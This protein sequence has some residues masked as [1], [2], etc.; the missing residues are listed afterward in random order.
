MTTPTS[1]LGMSNIQTEF[2]GSNPIALSEYYGVNANVAVSG[3]ITMASFLGI[4]SFPADPTQPSV[5]VSF[6]HGTLS[7]AAGNYYTPFIRR[8]GDLSGRNSAGATFMSLDAS[9]TKVWANT[10]TTVV[11]GFAPFVYTSFLNPN[12]QYYSQ[13][14]STDRAIIV[15]QSNTGV[16]LLASNLNWGTGNT[17]AYVYTMAPTSGTQNSN[18]SI[19]LTAVSNTAGSNTVYSTLKLNATDM[20]T[21]E[22][23]KSVAVG[24]D[25]ADSTSNIKPLYIWTNHNESSVIIAGTV[26]S[27]N[28]GV[29]VLRAS[30]GTTEQS[31]KVI[32]THSPIN[33]TLSANNIAFTN[34]VCCWIKSNTGSNVSSIGVSNTS[35]RRAM[36][37]TP[38]YDGDTYLWA[39]AQQGNTATVHTM[40]AKYNSAGTRQ[41]QIRIESLTSSNAAQVLHMDAS[42]TGVV[43][44]VYEYTMA[45][46]GKKWAITS[47]G[48]IRYLHIS[49]ASGNTGTMGRFSLTSNTTSV[50][51]GMSNTGTYTYTYSPR[52]TTEVTFQSK[53]VP[54]ATANGTTFTKTAL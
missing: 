47:T 23:V 6:W 2:G 8:T 11:A 24:R 5:T 20:T 33:K 4:S 43:L 28:T 9:G 17:N 32:N 53:A 7:W 19:F 30:D 35:W 13:W 21:I 44:V 52:N 40:V 31:W 14:N 41:W 22:W 27:T 37:A 45:H 1:V 26:T 39:S 42:N 3:V 15:K 10:Y 36:A 29:V 18:T 16:G 50:F 46:D 49:A 34:T 12:R 54:S 38:D 51:G 25:G 48:E